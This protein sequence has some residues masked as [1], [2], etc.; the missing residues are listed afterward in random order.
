M[1]DSSVLV[2]KQLKLLSGMRAG[3]SVLPK[4]RMGD[5]DNE[6]DGQLCNHSVM[7]PIP[8]SCDPQTQG[9]DRITAATS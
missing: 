8:T 5:E 7:D 4:F 3:E 2:V 9:E 6:N 1:V